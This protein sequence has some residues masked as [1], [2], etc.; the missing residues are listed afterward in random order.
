M[1]TGLDRSPK[2]RVRR[3]FKKWILTVFVVL[4]AGI[5]W[6]AV[7]AVRDCSQLSC[8]V[9]T[10]AANVQCENQAH[11][12]LLET[13][14]S[15]NAQELVLE[16]VQVARDQ[17]S[18]QLSIKL[19]GRFWNET[20]QNL[21]VFVG[22]TSPA[23]APVSY[24]LSADTQF[25]A[26][27]SYPIRNTI[28][29]Q[30][31]NEVRVGV[32]APGDVGYSPQIYITDPIRADLVGADA[33]LAVKAEGNEV[34][35]TLPLT[36]YYQRKQAAVPDRLSFTVATARDYVG[37]I[38]EMSVIDV[39]AQ[40]TKSANS[41]LQPPSDYP[42]LN[43]DSHVVKN[44]TLKQ[45]T[46]AP[47]EIELETLSQIN[48]W[49]QTN[50]YFYFVPEPNNNPGSL[51]S[52]PSHSITLPARW[53]YYCAVYSPHRLFC[54]TPAGDDFSYDTGYSER[55]VLEQ[56]KD[57]EFRELGGSKYVLSISA[58][59]GEQIKMGGKAFAVLLTIGRDGFGPSSCFGFNCGRRCNVL[60]RLK[61]AMP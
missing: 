18:A 26:D 3:G 43:Y 57:V 29:L 59:V 24:S 55:S 25:F 56:P 20:D 37:F 60:R 39:R 11:E 17:S 52:D 7:K 42:L 61:N 51:P 5:I 4:L 38:D 35:L 44:L 45:Q 10:G 53:S 16:S 47:L 34:V 22:Q 15:S 1:S 32:M 36:E 31:A 28:N 46:G 12:Q 14:P 33:H 41:K 27:V 48:D 19:K 23:A 49:A 21:Y 9:E 8:T 2:V 6:I 50:L 54:K 40:E 13:S 58:D 30:H